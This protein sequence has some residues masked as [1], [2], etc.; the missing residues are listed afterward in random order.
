MTRSAS[1]TR[2]PTARKEHARRVLH[3]MGRAADR[4]LR[5]AHLPRRR[6][7]FYVDG[8]PY[9]EDPGAIQLTDHKEIAIVIGRPPKDIPSRADFSGV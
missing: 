9:T 6:V 5:R 1:F 7:A 2:N 4:V 3:R 8:K